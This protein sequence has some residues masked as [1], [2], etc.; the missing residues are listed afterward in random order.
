MATSSAVT[1]LEATYAQPG[2]GVSRSCR[3]QP[4]WRSTAIRPPVETAA[5]IAPKTAMVTI[6]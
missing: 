1:A 5:P 6:S 3:F 2:I 4:A